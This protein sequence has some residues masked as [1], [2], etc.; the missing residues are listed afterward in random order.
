MSEYFVGKKEFYKG[1]G[2]IRF[3]GAGSDNPLAFRFYDP[4]KVIADK[5]MKDHFKFS[6]AYWHSLTGGGADPFGNPTIVHA[7][8]TSG[9]M[10]AAGNRADACFEVVTKLGLEYYCFHDR[11]AA[12]AG[13]SV[14]ES[15]KNLQKITDMLME[16]QKATGVKLLWN[17]VNAFHHPRY[18]NV[19]A[20]NPTLMW[21]P[22]PGHRSRLL[23]TPT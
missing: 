14:Q 8:E 22:M 2:K 16:R 11:D 19:A 18:M 15:E 3:E 21:Q 12:P 10:N 5:K 17:T 9:A 13:S 23:W 20:T 4:Q 6:L 7:W 1:I